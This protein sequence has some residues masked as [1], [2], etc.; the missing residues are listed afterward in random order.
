MGIILVPYILF[1][2]LI[3]LISSI[4]LLIKISKGRMHSWYSLVIGIILSVISYVSIIIYYS[5]LTSIWALEPFFILP[6]VLLLFPAVLGI[7]GMLVA[8]KNTILNRVGFGIAWIPIINI[9]MFIILPNISDPTNYVDI[10]LT[11]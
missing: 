1:S 9:L 6:A 5:T 2:L 7:I 4:M 11:H 3:V 10:T 8:K